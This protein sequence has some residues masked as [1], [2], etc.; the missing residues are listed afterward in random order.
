MGPRAETTLLSLIVFV[1]LVI[2]EQYKS[3]YTR[4][5]T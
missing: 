3:I 4:A 1:Q 2:G 5:R